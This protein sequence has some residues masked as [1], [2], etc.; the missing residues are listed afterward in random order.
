MINA[1][2]FDLDGVLID[3]HPIHKKAWSRFLAS[4][5]KPV[6]D[7]ELEFILDGR[8]RED[9]LIHFL[10]AL[11]RQQV[12]DYGRRKEQL[13][14]E[15]AQHVGM[16]AGI[17][18][19][20]GELRQRRV[21]MAVASSGSSSR[22]HFMLR[23]LG[24]Q[25]CFSAVVTGDDVPSG[26]PDPAIF[27]SAAEQLG[28]PP[29]ETLV[30][31]DAVSGVHAAKAAGM[32]CVGVANNGRGE[33]LRHAGAD[34]VITDFLSLRVDDCARLMNLPAS[35]ARLSLGIIADRSAQKVF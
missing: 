28:S 17:E 22:V 11:T 33:L 25:T 23:S 14:R 4:V 3:S 9:I 15:E 12:I 8:K 5:G 16:V 13:F 29:T 7:Q 20:L 30:F 26:K 18:R 34:H 1:V 19:F 32:R 2:I 24:L 31:E 27:R 10:G 21:P 6:N 35:T